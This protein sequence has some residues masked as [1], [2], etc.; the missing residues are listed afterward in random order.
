MTFI[1]SIFA[2]TLCTLIISCKKNKTPDPGPEVKPLL[3]TLLGWQKINLPE[4]IN[5]TDIYFS[6][7]Q[8][9]FFTY[10]NGIN[11]TADS[12][13]TWQSSFVKTGGYTNF[14]PLSASTFFVNDPQGIGYSYNAGISWTNRLGGSEPKDIFLH[15]MR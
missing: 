8:N 4:E 2:L 3:D 13:K 9:G 14:F 1:K 5:V 6:S 12:G 11:K 10:N 7:A 15:P